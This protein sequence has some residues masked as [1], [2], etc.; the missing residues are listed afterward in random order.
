MLI[1]ACYKIQFL[2]HKDLFIFF[3][4]FKQWV[5]QQD[6]SLDRGMLKHL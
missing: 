2:S 3:F 4:F 5:K 1:F 6:Q